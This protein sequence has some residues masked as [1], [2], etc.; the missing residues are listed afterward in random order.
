LKGK[1]TRDN[2]VLKKNKK[3]FLGVLN[4]AFLFNIPEYF[5]KLFLIGL[6]S[7]MYQRSIYLK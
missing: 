5:T 4:R 6:D 1:S 2:I 3:S 7:S